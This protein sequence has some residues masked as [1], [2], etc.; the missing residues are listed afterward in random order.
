[1]TKKAEAII[2]KLAA[3]TDYGRHTEEGQAKYYHGMAEAVNAVNKLE[4]LKALQK[5]HAAMQQSY[6]A[7]I[8]A[9][10][11]MSTLLGGRLMNSLMNYGQKNIKE[12]ITKV[13]SGKIKNKEHNPNSKLRQFAGWS[14][15]AAAKRLAYQS[16]RGVLGTIA[17][18]FGA[19]AFSEKGKKS[20]ENVLKK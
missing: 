15:E 12:K 6:Q 19:G 5:A 18:G 14:N 4:E 11:V 13:E 7:G 2:N 10:P 16:E 8:K 9:H 17:G 1:M 20:L 3:F